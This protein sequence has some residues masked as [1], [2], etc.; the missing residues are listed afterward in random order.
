MLFAIFSILFFCFLFGFC[1]ISSKIKVNELRQKQKTH[2]A[3]NTI[4]KRLQKGKKQETGNKEHI[5]ELL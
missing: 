1:F 3:R 4:I 2:I 5:I